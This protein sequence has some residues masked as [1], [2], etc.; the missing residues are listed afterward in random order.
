MQ[1]EVN[2]RT[3][4][5]S[6]RASKLTG[7]VLASAFSKVVKAAKGHHQKALTPKGRQSVKKLLNHRGDKTSIPYVGAPKDFDRIAK[8]YEVDYAFRKVSPGHYLLFFKAA[9][10][11][12]ITEAMRK[13][14]EKVL[15]K[16]KEKT[17]ILGQLRRFTEL[18]R[19][20]PK[21]KQRTREAVKDGR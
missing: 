11:G 19:A 17:S 6:I 21:K 5:L 9:Q 7:K 14:S 2:Q 8:I 10:S 16:G 4:A 15:H 18:V 20:K 12:D 3:M 1:E 13:Y